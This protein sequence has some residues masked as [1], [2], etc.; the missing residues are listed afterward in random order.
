MTDR[1]RVKRS[2]EFEKSRRNPIKYSNDVPNGRLKDGDKRKDHRIT[3][4]EYHKRGCGAFRTKLCCWR[5]YFFFM[6]S[7]TYPRRID[8]PYAA[9]VVADRVNISV[10]GHFRFPSVQ[11]AVTTTIR[12]R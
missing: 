4:E 11:S 3:A 6:L 1:F 10:R 7:F 5:N 8:K 12:D 9:A 2:L